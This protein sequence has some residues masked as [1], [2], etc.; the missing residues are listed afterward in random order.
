MHCPAIY[1][2]D[3]YSASQA[4][5]R[6]LRDQ[7]S[8]GIAY[9]SVRYGGGECVGVFRPPALRNC[10]QERH[11]CYV[12]NG[13]Q[14]IRSTKKVLFKG[15]GWVTRCMAITSPRRAVLLFLRL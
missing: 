5:G 14:S 8:W 4:L 15:V 10:R 1:A 9:D 7:N 13:K 2:A 6:R 11:L 3:D 12:W